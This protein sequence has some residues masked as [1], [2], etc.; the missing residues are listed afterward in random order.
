MKFAGLMRGFFGL[1]EVD[2]AVPLEVA[3][4]SQP[5]I[6][7]AGGKTARSILPLKGLAVRWVCSVVNGASLRFQGV[8][9]PWSIVSIHVTNLGSK[10]G[11]NLFPSLD[12]QAK[13]VTFNG[14]P[15]PLL[16]VSGTGEYI[17]ALAPSEMPVSGV[18]TMKVAN[19]FGAGNDFSLQMAAAAPGIYRS[20]ACPP[21]ASTAPCTGSR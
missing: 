9:S 11:T 8:A 15:A 7:E 4:G 10:E 19:E 18:V 17:D 13:S 20:C 3:P 16:T 5:V 1:Y 6:V 12:F 21:A 2:F 14:V